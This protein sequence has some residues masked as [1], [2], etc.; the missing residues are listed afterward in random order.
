MGGVQFR[1]CGMRLR[2]LEENQILHHHLQQKP[3]KELDKFNAS[4]GGE[5]HDGRKSKQ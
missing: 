3:D 5:W 4:M 2:M 1:I